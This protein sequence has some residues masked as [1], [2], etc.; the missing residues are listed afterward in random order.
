M[1]STMSEH[2]PTT[3]R[4][5]ILKRLRVFAEE[6]KAAEQAA[7]HDTLARA[8]DIVAL[9]EDKSWV[10]EM[11]APKRGA[12]RSRPVDPESF[13]RFTK[14]LAERTPIHGRRAYQLRDAHEMATTYLH[15]VQISPTG[16]R[17][18][19]PFKWFQ[20]NGYED[21]IP[22]VWRL[23]CQLAGGHSPDGPTVRKA[24]SQWKADNLPK[25][26]GTG[27][28]RKRSGRAKVERWREEALRLMREYPEDFARALATV[29]DGA[30]AMLGE[31]EAPVRPLAEIEAGV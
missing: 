14:W 5:L 25:A 29:E 23:A 30:E 16:E 8:A 11:P 9:Y 20:K 21:R 27:A 6:Q 15:R 12:V 4:D 18:V 1:T 28:S 10:G 31:L 24:I 7:D 3:D 2:M 19:R 22:E 26:E 17:A 13:S